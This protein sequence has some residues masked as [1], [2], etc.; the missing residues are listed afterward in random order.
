[1]AVRPSSG[2]TLARM[3]NPQADPKGQLVE[4][5][6]ARLDTGPDRVAELTLAVAPLWRRTGIGNEMLSLVLRRCQASRIRRL[7]AVVDPNNRPAL[8]FFRDYGFEDSGQCGGA[9]RFVLWIHEADPHAI[10]IEG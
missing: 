8:G 6:F 3:N 4:V 9:V 2:A 5:G 10:E 1:M 7:H